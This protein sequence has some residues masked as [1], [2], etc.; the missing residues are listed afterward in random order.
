MKCLSHDL[1]AF[2]VMHPHML[3]AVPYTDR[4]VSD[5]ATIYEAP[6]PLDDLASKDSIGGFHEHTILLKV[7]GLP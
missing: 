4:R 6:L 7:T 1:N 3:V 2:G 5:E